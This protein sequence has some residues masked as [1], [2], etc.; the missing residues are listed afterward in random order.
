MVFDAAVSLAFV[1]HYFVITRLSREQGSLF[2][3]T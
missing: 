3:Y 2:C 1:Y